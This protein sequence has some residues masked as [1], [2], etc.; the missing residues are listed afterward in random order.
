MQSVTATEREEGRDRVPT[1]FCFFQSLQ[2]SPQ[3]NSVTLNM[4]AARSCEIA[5]KIYYSIPYNNPDDY[6]LSN[7]CSENLKPYI[8]LRSSVL[9]ISGR[10]L[11]G[12]FSTV[13]PIVIQF[14]RI[15][16]AVRKQCITQHS[17]FLLFNRTYYKPTDTQRPSHSCATTVLDKP[18]YSFL[19][20]NQLEHACLVR[21][22][23]MEQKVQRRKTD[24]KEVFWKQ[25]AQYLRTKQIHLLQNVQVKK[26]QIL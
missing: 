7:N 20:C 21:R 14:T 26:N 13:C 5:G 23:D 17:A 4:M 25:M 3:S 16:L 19:P 2:H 18:S 9:S 22:N 10:K 12:A 24:Q 8:S 1:L 6:H 15:N 11:I